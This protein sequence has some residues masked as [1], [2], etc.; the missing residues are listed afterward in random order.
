MQDH[1]ASAGKQTRTIVYLGLTLLGA[2]V[3]IV[4]VWMTGSTLGQ[5]PQEDLPAI[6]RQLVQPSPELTPDDV[7]RLQ[8]RALGTSAISDEGIL[9]C[10]CFASPANRRATGPFP[11]FVAMI[12]SGSYAAMLNQT[13][14][15]VGRPIVRGEHARVLA[16]FVDG[17]RR[18]RV[19]RFELS[20]QS[21]DPYLDCWMTDEVTEV[22][23]GRPSDRPPA[24]PI[25][26][27]RSG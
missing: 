12:R 20:K 3:T 9:Q 18:V 10:Y 15:R 11:R 21:A 5:K 23:A 16:T 1:Q 2:V 7:V 14:T 26:I 13:A 4:A 24:R 6:A 17:H 22:A 8:L 27:E 19:Y 25:R